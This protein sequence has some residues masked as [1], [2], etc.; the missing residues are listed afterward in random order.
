MRRLI[1]EFLSKAD[2]EWS[3]EEL[4]RLLSG[5]TLPPVGH[6]DEPYAWVLEG[7]VGANDEESRAK[8]TAFAGRLARLVDENPEELEIQDREVM[9]H[10]LFS[11]CSEL[12]RADLLG[13]P[14]W[15]LYGRWKAQGLALKLERRDLRH[16]LRSAL[17]ANQ[18]DDRLVP[19]W[20]EMGMSEAGSPP[21]NYLLGDATQAFQGTISCPA[22]RSGSNVEPLVPALGKVAVGLSPER[23]VR[24]S[25]LKRYIDRSQEVVP[26]FKPGKEPIIT[27]AARHGFPGWTALSLFSGG[28]GL[29]PYLELELG[30]EV[31]VL[32]SVG[33]ALHT[34]FNCPAPTV[35]ARDT[36]STA[37]SPLGVLLVSVRVNEAG[38]RFLEKLASYLVNNSEGE[39]FA[40]SICL[41]DVFRISLEDALTSN[42]ISPGQPAFD[43][44]LR[45]FDEHYTCALAG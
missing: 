35:L 28:D 8:E 20:Q 17:I 10:G 29:L 22:V 31:I 21:K 33:K 23:R 19:E 25:R 12:S 45:E 5:E 24:D 27:L 34:S 11:L 44:P 9:L 41:V 37:P 14:L 42:N 6:D 18:V 43:A 38:R 39:R 13:E 2:G 7:L 16:D 36:H 40:N 30:N 4:G 1:D 32:S 15:R 3:T 26:S